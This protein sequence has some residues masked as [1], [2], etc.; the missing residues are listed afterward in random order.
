MNRYDIEA[1]DF[2]L[3]AQGV[4]LLRN[5]FNYKTIAFDDI[6]RADFRRAVETKNVVLTLVAGAALIVF[7]ILQIIGVIKSFNNP[8]VHVIYIESIGLPVLPLLLGGYCIYISV[9]KVPSLIIEGKDE[10]HKLSVKEIV[11]NQALAQLETYLK[12]KL[13]SRFSDANGHIA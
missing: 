13:G 5:R 1:K 7:S 10:K 4:H 3:S 12:A 6:D 9:K 11:N 2:A 8:H